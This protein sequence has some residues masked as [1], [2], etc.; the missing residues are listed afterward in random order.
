MRIKRIWP[1]PLVLALS[2]TGCEV[3]PNYKEPVMPVTTSFDAGPTTQPASAAGTRANRRPVDVERWWT[4]F[5][6]PELDRL[7]GEAVASNLDIKVA[8]MRVQEARAS[9][10][11]V[12]GGVLPYLEGSGGAARGSGTNSVKGRISQPLNAATN[13]TGLTEITQVVGFDAGWEI[14]I[15]GRFRREMEAAAA[16]SQ[17]AEEMRNGVVVTLVSDVARIYI[18][19]R[20]TQLRLAIANQNIDVAQQTLSLVQQRF[21]R[22]L[23]NELDFALARRQLASERAAVAPLQ[24]GIGDLQR[25]LAVL[26]GQSP[27]TLYSELQLTPSLPA[28]PEKLV[29]GVPVDLLRR[30]PDIRESERRLAAESAQI[31]VATAE[32][33]PRIAIT[34][35]LGLQGQGLGRQPTTNSFIWSVGPT[36]EVPIFDFGRIDSMIQ[37][38][39]YRTQEQF[40]N[41]KQTVLRAIE[42]V[43]NAASNYAAQQDRLEQ[44]GEALDASKRAVDLATGRYERGLI[45]FLNVLDAQR[46]LYQLQD[47]YTLA[48]QSVADGYIAVYKALGGGWQP[49]KDVPPIQR[50]LPAVFAAAAHTIKPDGEPYPVDSAAPQKPAP[51]MPGDS[52]GRTN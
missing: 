45:D 19:M 24:E 20:A 49:Y 4:S 37:L 29:A 38:E 47:E 36:A 14:D 8:L 17:V 44:L 41:Y 25:R 12:T 42:E 13:T 43:D 48:Q 34:G 26:L 16:D 39:N 40:Y 28:P 3:G 6:D 51:Q 31:G 9:A 46:Q 15:F 27:E 35:G 21:D 10:N 22:G 33:F 2:V 50:P 1:V 7:I 52:S 11:V 23:T 32:L 5:N 30:R 18:E